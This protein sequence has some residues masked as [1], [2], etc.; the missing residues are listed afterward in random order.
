VGRE[1]TKESVRAASLELRRA[2]RQVGIVRKSEPSQRSVGLGI[3]PGQIG[4]SEGGVHAFVGGTSTKNN[5]QPGGMTRSLPLNG[6]NSAG[7][8]DAMFEGIGNNNGD[9]EGEEKHKASNERTRR[10]SLRGIGA[11]GKKKE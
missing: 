6:R 11:K 8:E 10:Y 7:H 5:L 3:A 2:P 9:D 1:Q 4:R